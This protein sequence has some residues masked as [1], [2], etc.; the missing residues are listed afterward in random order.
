MKKYQV[1]IIILTII[2]VNISQ[3]TYAIGPSGPYFVPKI[4]PDKSTDI[5]FNESNIVIIGKIESNRK[6]GETDEAYLYEATVIVEEYLR[7]NGS[8]KINVYYQNIKPEIAS[9]YERYYINFLPDEKVVLCLQNYEDHYNLTYGIQ[10][11]FSFNGKVYVN[12]NGR[13]WSPPTIQFPYLG[14]LFLLSIPA[15]IFIYRRFSK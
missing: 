15:Y 7:G 2:A 3:P 10:G 14:F 12:I 5:L 13:E 8:E 6:K 1:F 9:M 11:K 4:M